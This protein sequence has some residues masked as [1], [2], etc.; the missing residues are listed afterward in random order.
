M[1]MAQAWQKLTTINPC[2]V[3]VFREEVEDKKAAS[4]IDIINNSDQSVIFKVSSQST[5][6]LGQNHPTEKLHRQTQPRRRGAQE[7]NAN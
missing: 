3:I 1:A 7:P 4:Y 5:H 2:D 6:L